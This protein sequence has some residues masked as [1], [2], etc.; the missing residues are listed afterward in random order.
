MNQ[1]AAANNRNI[2]KHTGS[3]FISLAESEDEKKTE[4]NTDEKA[5]DT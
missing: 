2:N 1:D 4:T 5:G 3:V